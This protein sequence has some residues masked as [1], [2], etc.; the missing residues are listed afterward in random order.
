MP[1]DHLPGSPRDRRVGILSTYPPQRCGLATFAAS[2]EL[3]LIDAGDDV[4]VV[5]IDDGR[6]DGSVRSKARHELVNGLPTS[7]RDAARALSRCDV[8]IIQHEYGIYGGVDGD[9]VLDILEQL[10]V[11]AIVVLHTV[12]AH[13]TANQQRILEAISE[14]AA[15]VVVMT[16]AAGA[17]LTAKPLPDEEFVWEG[18]ADDIRPVVREVLTACDGCADSLLDVEHRTA[19]RRFLTRA[20]VGD[21]S[22]FRRKASPVR[23]AAAVAWAVCRA[24]GTVGGS[25]SPLSVQELLD[26]FEVK[27]AVSQRAEP[28]LRAIGA[29]PRWRYGEI[30]LGTP[31]LLVSGC[32]ADIIEQRERWLEE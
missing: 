11:P 18:I 9:E 29:D 10:E 26:W 8:A 27:G 13:P 5:A 6:G 19:M 21:P 24:N 7:V 20:A 15:A 3:E 16:D 12:P 2:L 14:G 28:L 1:F 32:R 22:V 31:D 4:T 23:G 17:R 30:A 25:G